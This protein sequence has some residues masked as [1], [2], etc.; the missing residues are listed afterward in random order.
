MS[1]SKAP[2]MFKRPSQ[3]AAVDEAKIRELEARAEARGNG[4]AGQ[5]ES[6][7]AIT[8]PKESKLRREQG[9]VRIAGYVSSELEHALR[10]H[11]AQERRSMSDALTE[12]VSVLLER[13]SDRAL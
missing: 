6:Q 7:S 12:A 3:S 8:V 10:M 5:P 13:Y 11:C 1:P 9:G 2:L 4:V